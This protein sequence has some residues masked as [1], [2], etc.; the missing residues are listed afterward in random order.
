MP[1]LKKYLI[2]YYTILSMQITVGKPVER[3]LNEVEPPPPK[4][5]NNQ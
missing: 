3:L 1:T 2:S 5:S 4:K